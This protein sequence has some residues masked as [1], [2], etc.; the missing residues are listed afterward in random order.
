VVVVGK[1]SVT[2]VAEEALCDVVTGCCSI[3][4]FSKLSLVTFDCMRGKGGEWKAGNRKTPEERGPSLVLPPLF[5]VGVASC[6]VGYTP[7]LA[8]VCGGW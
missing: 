8:L 4:V 6:V 7:Q 3:V 2:A 5:H 1:E